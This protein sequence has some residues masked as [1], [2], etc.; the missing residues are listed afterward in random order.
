MY[1]EDQV[2]KAQG[3]TSASRRQAARSEEADAKCWHFLGSQLYAQL[4]SALRPHFSSD[5]LGSGREFPPSLS[6]CSSNAQPQR[7]SAHLE[8]TAVPDEGLWL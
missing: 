7:S 8:L 3:H 1:D 5:L 6:A 2:S 4:H